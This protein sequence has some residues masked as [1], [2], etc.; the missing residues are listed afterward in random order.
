MSLHRNPARALV[1][2][3]LAASLV[4]WGGGRAGASTNVDQA[5][6]KL[7]SLVQ[8]IDSERAGLDAIQARLEA[9]AV[10]VR[11]VQGRLAAMA[12]QVDAATAGFADVER[13]LMQTRDDLDAALSSYRDAQG[14]LDQQARQAYMFGSAFGLEAVLGAASLADLSDRVEFVE[15]VSRDQ[16]AASA[17]AARRSAALRTEQQRLGSLLVRRASS[18]GDLADRTNALQAAF[19]SQQALLA[20]DRTQLRQEQALLATLDRERRQVD[21][22]VTRL[23]TGLS[24]AEL[25]DAR[26]ASAAAAA[27]HD[28]RDS[29]MPISFGRWAALLMP[30]MGAPACTDNLIVTVAWETQ[31]FTQAR[32][33]P[34]ATTKDMPGATDFNSSGVR[35]YR[36][37]AQGL[38]AT[39]LTLEDGALSWGYGAILASLR[40]CADPMTTARAINASAWCRGCEGGGY[41]TALVPAVQAWFSSH[42]H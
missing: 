29:P 34:L 13:R 12:P 37:L 33:N 26:A 6:A 32:W 24:P 18:L 2:F 36:S 31:E 42:P 40:S 25:A 39:R 16:A 5:R 20:T 19:A 8:R 11:S 22:L 30:R 41:V 27:A 17:E 4:S 21:A 35:D 10:S 1:A 3:A 23:A 9:D 15:T 38:E 28:G 7:A 14:R